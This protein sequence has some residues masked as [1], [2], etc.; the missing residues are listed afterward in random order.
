MTDLPRYM[1]DVGKVLDHGLFNRAKVPSE[2]WEA[3]SRVIAE[4]GGHGLKNLLENMGL[5]LIISRQKAWFTLMP[6]DKDSK[7]RI[8]TSDVTTTLEKGTNRSAHFAYALLAVVGSF[9]P[10]RYALNNNQINE[11]NFDT[12]FGIVDKMTDFIKASSNMDDEKSLRVLSTAQSFSLMPKVNEGKPT[13]SSLQDYYI[14]RALKELED[15][16]W[17]KLN[18]SKWL[19]TEHFSLICQKRLQNDG[20]AMADLLNSYYDS[21]ETR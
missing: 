1:S 15:A 8:K 9:F 17:V 10:T 19:P 11:V 13:N 16:K 6:Q 21:L 14:R 12:V 18:G 4:D 7:F 3:Y 20:F 2:V 5:E